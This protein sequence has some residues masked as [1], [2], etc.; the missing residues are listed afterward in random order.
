MT[1]LQKDRAKKGW[2]FVS[3][4]GTGHRLVAVQLSYPS[5]TATYRPV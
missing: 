5:A 4:T 1:P 2:D 3:G